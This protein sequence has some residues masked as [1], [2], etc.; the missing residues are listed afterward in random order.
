MIVHVF[1]VCMCMVSIVC[2]GVFF[3]DNDHGANNK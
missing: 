1:D 2:T 3:Q